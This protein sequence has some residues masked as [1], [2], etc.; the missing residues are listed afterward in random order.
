MSDLTEKK[1]SRSGHPHP[2]FRL[3]EEN[4]TVCVGDVHVGTK[5]RVALQTTQDILKGEKVKGPRVL[6][7]SG[8]QKSFVTSTAMNNASC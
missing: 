6:L 1:Q 8:S 7:D 5:C 3:I 2:N 4:E